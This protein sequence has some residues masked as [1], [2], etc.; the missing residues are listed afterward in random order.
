MGFGAVCHGVCSA[1]NDTIP[2]VYES[3]NGLDPL[4]PA[5]A[6]ADNDE[7]GFTNLE[8]FEAG[9]DPQDPASTPRKPLDFLPLLL[10]ED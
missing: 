1:V 8:E 4:D 7:D 10:F 5:D 6:N 9:S 2:D 3:A